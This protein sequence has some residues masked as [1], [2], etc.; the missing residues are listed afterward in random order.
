VTFLPSFKV[1]RDFDRTNPCCLPPGI[2]RGLKERGALAEVTLPVLQAA[3]LCV[4]RL[5]RFSIGAVEWEHA[6]HRSFCRKDLPWSQF[7]ALS[8]AASFREQWLCKLKQLQLLEFRKQAEAEAQDLPAPPRGRRKLR[9]KAVSAIEAFRND[10]MRQQLVVGEVKNFVSKDAW[11]AVHKAF[12]ELPE[13]RRRCYEEQSRA[14][15][16]VAAATRRLS[17]GGTPERPDDQAELAEPLAGPAAEEG[18][19]LQLLPRI[20]DLRFSLLALPSSVGGLN[21]MADCTDHVLEAIS[22]NN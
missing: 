10:W 19:S 12:S 17:R 20:Q 2:P 18:G 1:Q 13:A 8:V 3:L 22:D 7:A 6:R 14:S 16:T 4:A 9:Q 5:L 15:K 11:E 21:R